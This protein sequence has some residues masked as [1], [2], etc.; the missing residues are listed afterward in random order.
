MK[1]SR[2]KRR[3]SAKKERKIRRRRR[4]IISTSIVCGFLLIAAA[5]GIRGVG[6]IVVDILNATNELS[7]GSQKV[8][9]LDFNGAR[10][11]L[12][13]AEQNLLEVK[14]KLDHPIYQAA[15]RIPLFG[16]KITAIGMIASSE[17]EATR[18]CLSLIDA[19]RKFSGSRPTLEIR[20]SAE[21][22]DLAQFREAMPYINQARDRLKKALKMKDKIIKEHALSATENS[23]EIYSKEIARLDQA[24]NKA[25]K[26]LNIIPAFLGSKKERRYFLAVQNNAKPRATGGVIEIYGILVASNG[27]LKLEKMEDVYKLQ[28]ENM[29]EAL[30]TDEYRNRYYQFGGTSSWENSNISPDFPSVSN[31]ILQLYESSTGEHLDGVIAIDLV[32]LKYLMEATGPIEIPSPDAVIDSGNIIK[33]VL[34][35]GNRAQHENDGG[36]GDGAS[37]LK[38]VAGAVWRRF[39]IGNF[40]N[41]TLLPAKVIEALASKH[42]IVFSTDANE[43]RIFC[44]LGCGGI[45]SDGYE[46]YLQV[47]VQNLGE[48]KGST[49]INQAIEYDVSIKQNRSMR[50][51]V[52]VTLKNNAPKTG[53]PS[54]ALEEQSL[55][56]KDKQENVYLSVYVPG[57]SRLLGFAYDG[58]FGKP[59]IDHEKNKTIFSCYLNI[60]AGEEQKVSF[61]YENPYKASISGGPL[62]YC[63][64]WQ[65]QPTIE[66]PKIKIN[67]SHPAGYQ[68]QQT[69]DGLIQDG[70]SVVANGAL[71]KDTLYTIVLKRKEMSW[72]EEFNAWLKKLAF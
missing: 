63:L 14:L 30:T 36:K 6:T 1:E 72:I 44:E 55:S 41:R 28:K 12:L 29:P 48:D 42:M 32:G 47:L 59:E 53:S 3:E 26:A 46:D 10:K 65:V 11:D 33:T 7:R 68:V 71:Q 51:K 57:K 39:E 61:V 70:R 2:Y 13:R 37:L 62:S 60:P 21:G 43:E 49:H 35:D 52:I 20:Y 58:K 18:A 15:K 22:V 31:V 38:E 66:A 69:T 27:K 16:N 56:E 40:K 54:F 67:I 17:I 64:K 4:L 19:T 25:E 5:W 50:S 34:S 45:L 23:L 9:S 24:I 8:R